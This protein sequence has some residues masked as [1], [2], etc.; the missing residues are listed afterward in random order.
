MSYRILRPWLSLAIVLIISDFVEAQQHFKLTV[1]GSSKVST[2]ELTAKTLNVVI[3]GM[4]HTYTRDPQY[5]AA[6]Y[7][8]YVNTGLKQVVRWP[9]AGQNKMQIGSIVSAGRVAYKPSQM[10]ITA[11]GAAVT[12]KLPAPPG[13]SKPGSAVDASFFYR[14]TNE[15]VGSGWA[16]DADA[17]SRQMTMARSGKFK[18]QYWHLTPV[19]GGLVRLTNAEMGPQWSLAVDKQGHLQIATTMKSAE[20]LWRVTAN[21]K[22]YRFTNDALNL[23]LDVDPKQS[24]QPLVDKDDSWQGERWL[25]VQL[26]QDR[27]PPAGQR[28]VSH[29]PRPV[30]PLEPAN[31]EFANKH[32]K[33]LWVLITDL[34]DPLHPLRLKIP[35]GQAQTV[36]LDRD[37]GSMIVET[38]EIVGP[39]GEVVIEERI[40][41]LPPRQLYDVSVYELIIQSISIDNTKKGKGRIEQ[42]NAS[43]KSLGAFPLPAGSALA[44]QTIDVFEEAELQENPGGVRRIDPSRWQ[45]AP[46]K[47]HPIERRL[48]EAERRNQTP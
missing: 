31:V 46:E 2:A 13:K 7:Q 1:P 9:T 11:V 41:E 12:G 39:G 18:S 45:Q 40:S 47:I 32:G 17:R 44:D 30:S 27:V 37:P 36:L 3:G 24:N 19:A 6:G 43:P 26:H 35:P 29:E 20:Q 34:R 23:P 28:L 5:D 14:L 21:G 15:A 22:G 16:L 8:A 25:L 42:V 4:T 48:Q 38:W 33:E 10:Q